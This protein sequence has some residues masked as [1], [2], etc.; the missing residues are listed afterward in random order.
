MPTRTLLSCSLLIGT[1][2]ACGGGITP[3][4]P[5]SAQGKATAASARDLGRRS[6]GK[7]ARVVLLLRYNHEAELER[8]VDRL[9]RDPQPHYLAR[10]EFLARYAPT[11]SQEHRVLSA[12]HDAGL[13]VTRRYANRLIVDAVGPSVN[14][15]RLFS[16]EIHDFQQPQYGVRAANIRPLRIPAQL[17]PEVAAA[18][19]N[20]LVLLHR[21]SDAAATLPAVKYENVVSNGSFSTG[22]LAPWTSCGAASASVSRRHPENGEYDAL[23]GSATSASEVKGWSAIC[24][25]VTVPRNATL[26][27]WLYQTT[28]E[29]TERNAYQ[30]IALADAAGKPA[31]EL[32]KTNANFAGWVHRTWSLAKYAGKT[33]TLFFG[34]YGSGRAKHYDTQYVDNVSLVGAAPTPTPVP[35]LGPT[36]GWGPS[37]VTNGLSLPVA[38]GDDGKGETAAIVIDN[39]VSASDLAA[40]L[41]YFGITRTGTVTDEPIDG[42]GS[43]PGDALE[44]ALDVETIASLAPGANIIVYNPAVLSDTDV[45]DAYNQIVSDGKATVVNSSFSEC[46]TVDPTFDSI[47]DGIALG[48]SAQGVTFAASS[49]DYGPECYD[50]GS[51]IQ[52]GAGA[53]ASDPHFVGVGGTQSGSTNPNVPVSGPISNP[54]V[55]DDL[56][57]AGGNGVSTIWTPPPY[58]T[59]VAGVQPSGRNVPDIALPAAHDS[60][61]LNGSWG[62]VW[63][64]SWASPI[65]VA[66]QAEIN[67][68]CTTSQ[69]G[70]DTLYGAFAKTAY[71]YD[72]VDVV[73]GSNSFDGA[74]GESALPG[75]DSV[76]G[77]G[78]PIGT[79]IATDEC[80]T[81]R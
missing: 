58:Q 49:G 36:G 10:Q 24:Q 79:Q 35:G 32:A 3:Q 47:T 5:G 21:D 51:S 37:D 67:Q 30:E 50:G 28:N 40:F 43:T 73:K 34:V 1:L 74:T 14:V 75:F 65:Y 66:M 20:D 53:P 6:P 45:E 44:A 4:V 23:T 63:G 46:D 70:I 38:Y 17:A 54:A 42:G 69:W 19:A 31:I 27:A 62:L 41:H 29:P 64:T 16:T 59:G 12:L 26:G 2:A 68:V 71:K 48:A 13:R 57:G 81:R 78:I 56:L 76:S 15:E 22:K 25:R 7:P 33:E 52:R 60:V 11:V 9:E 55:W 77:I 72:F 8:F 39:T 80:G 61:Y 18:E